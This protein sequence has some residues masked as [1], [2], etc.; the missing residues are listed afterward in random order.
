VSPLRRK[1][2]LVSEA[3][4]QGPLRHQG[5]PCFSTVPR[6]CCRPGAL[7]YAAG[8][9]RRHR[10]SAGSRWRKLNPGEQA[11]LVLVYLRKGETLSELAAGVGIGTTTA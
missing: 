5:L 7:A 10:K 6:C 11:L 2:P 8:I 1:K 9:I 3:I 4:D